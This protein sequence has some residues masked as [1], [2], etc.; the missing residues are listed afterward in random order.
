MTTCIFCDI[1]NG[2][3][4]ADIVDETDDWLA[5]RDISPRAPTHI[6]VIPR[7]HVASLAEL[8]DE[9]LGGKLLSACTRVARAAGIETGFRVVTNI[10]EKGGQAVFHLHLHVLG[11][12][13][14]SWPPG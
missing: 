9:Q 7:T 3:I 1:A 4:P 11:G 2:K 5:F 14:M 13:R 8:E 12:R 10:G 6:L